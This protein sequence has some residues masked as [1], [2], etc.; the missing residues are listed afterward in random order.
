MA[1]R[2][3]TDDS[4]DPIHALDLLA[5]E[6]GKHDRKKLDAVIAGTSNDALVK[7]GTS[8]L[9]SRVV[10]DGLR[11]YTEA[12]HFWERATAPQKKCLRGFSLPLL[13]LA[14]HQLRELHQL[15][16]EVAGETLE[17]GKTRAVKQK[18]ADAASTK[19][20]ALRDQAYDALRDAA[21]QDVALRTLVEQSFGTTEDG[22]A[23]GKGLDGLADVLRGWL[24]DKKNAGMAERLELANLDATYADELTAAAKSVRATAAGAVRPRGGTKATQAALDREDGVNVL[25][26]GQIIRAFDG[27]HNIDPTIPRLVPISTQ[28]LFNRNVKKKKPEAGGDSSDQVVE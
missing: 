28:R 22:E 15:D 20:C 9:T 7:I 3:K 10:T 2:S 23:L 26:L 8:I 16:K 11:L 13:A 24:K 4:D 27:A 18:S 12:W 19:G 6:V 21:G 17:A 1:P 14:V 25:L 5:E